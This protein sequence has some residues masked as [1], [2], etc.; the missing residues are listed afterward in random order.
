MITIETSTLRREPKIALSVLINIKDQRIRLIN[1][2]K[3]IPF[4][5]VEK[6]PIAHRRKPQ[7][8]QMILID[9]I[10]ALAVKSVLFG[11]LLHPAGI[12]IHPN[13][14]I[15]ISAYPEIRSVHTQSMHI[16]GRKKAA[17][18]ISNKPPRLF[19]KAR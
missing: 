19:I 17:A 7:T 16:I 5:V 13:H 2:M 14:S 15:G 8:P 11:I 6:Y 4:P 12:E 18:G 3:A 10:A 1:L 9:R